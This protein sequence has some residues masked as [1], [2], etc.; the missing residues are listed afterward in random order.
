MS[1][2]HFAV[3][4]SRGYR[5]RQRRRVSNI[6]PVRA[7]PMP[8][9]IASQVGQREEASDSRVGASGPEDVRPRGAC[10]ASTAPM[11]SWESF[12][13]PGRG[14]R[15]KRG[16]K[17]HGGP[18]A[19]HW[20]K[21]RGNGRRGHG[22]KWGRHGWAPNDRWSG[23]STTKTKVSLAYSKT[24]NTSSMYQRS[25]NCIIVTSTLTSM[26]KR[27]LNATPET[28]NMRTKRAVH[29]N[30]SLA[31]SAALNTLPRERARSLKEA[32]VV[33]FFKNKKHTR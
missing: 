31:A 3:A 4:P 29:I 24:I 14:D 20:R 12:R 16:G 25:W 26:Y 21:P 11:P 13:R 19:R 15:G 1:R 2:L 6:P 27:K 5:L 32:C 23:M 8:G 9:R 17:G 22:V 18:T 7:H 30:M 10:D 33:H 28:H